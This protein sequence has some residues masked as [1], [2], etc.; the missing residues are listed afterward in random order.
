MIEPDKQMKM[1]LTH[2]TEVCSRI[3][4]TL[5]DQ[6]AVLYVSADAQKQSSRV[7]ISSTRPVSEQRTRYQDCTRRI[8]GQSLS[9]SSRCRHSAAVFECLSCYCDFSREIVLMII[10]S[11]RKQK[12]WVL[13]MVCV[14]STDPLVC[15]QCG[16][17]TSFNGGHETDVFTLRKM[18]SYEYMWWS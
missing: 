13:W 7:F 4:E 1:S 15:V 8:V 2:W 17:L 12:H 5:K 9:P 14:P 6:S 11:E 16:S 3:T 18:I 10:G